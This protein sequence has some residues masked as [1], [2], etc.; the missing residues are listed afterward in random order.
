MLHEHDYGWLLERDYEIYPIDKPVTP[1]VLKQWYSN[2]PDFGIIFRENNEIFGTNITIP[3]N[4]TGWEGLI[5]G[6][7]TEAECN[8]QY[9][10]NNKSDTEIGLHV[11]HIK[12]TSAI[13]GF[14]KYSL[15]ALHEIMEDLRRSNKGLRIIGLSALCVTKM[16]I[17]LFY[18]KLNC[19]ESGVIVHEHILKKEDRLVIFETKSHRELRNKLL[20]GYEYINRCKMLV[21]HPEEPSLVWEYLK[22]G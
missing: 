15:K 5:S 10:F 21:L 13:R 2:N 3:L 1:R 16:G 14:Y 17:G 6:R 18:N 19:R 8:K 4:R 9:I 20:M 22:P 11:Y 7:I 12:K